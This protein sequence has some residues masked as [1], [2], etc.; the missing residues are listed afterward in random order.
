MIQITL[1]IDE[2][3]EPELAEWVKSFHIKGKRLLSFNIRKAINFYLKHKD[4]SGPVH[5]SGTE[6]GNF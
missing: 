2:N 4:E 1:K 3:Q 5:P 6:A